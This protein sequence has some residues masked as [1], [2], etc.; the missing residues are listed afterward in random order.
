MLPRLLASRAAAAFKISLI[1]SSLGLFCAFTVYA[2]GSVSTCTEEALRTALAGGGTVT[3]S[4]NCSITLT[5]PL[6]I[7]LATTIDA[8]NHDVTISGGNAVSLFNVTANLNL[9]GLT[10]SNG[11][12][13]NGTGGCMHIHSGATVR[14]SDCSFVANSVQGLNGFAGSNGSTNSNGAGG[15]GGNG[16]AGLSGLGGAIYNLGNLTLVGCNFMTN[17]ATGGNGGKGGNGGAGGGTLSQGGDGGDGGAGAAGFGG[18]IYNLNNTTLISCTFSNNAAF[19]GNGGVGGT[20]GAGI[21]PSLQG[22][23]GP[24]EAGSGGSIYNARNLTVRS[25]TFAKN[26]AESGISA[27]GGNQTSGVGST[28]AA[29]PDSLGGALCNLWWGV[30]TN[31]TFFGNAAFGGI[32]GNGGNGSGSLP[33]GGNGGN[34]GN[35]AGG[36]LY[37]SG[38]FTLVNCT[39]SDNGAVGGTNGVAGSGNFASS[40]GQMGQSLGGNIAAAGGSLNVMN[41]ILNASSSGANAF[42]AFTDGGYN[43]SSDTVDSFDSSTLQNTDPKLGP[44]ANNGGPTFTM[45]LLK[46]SPAVDVIP[47]NRAPQS[48]QRGISRPQGDASDIG[49]YEFTGSSLPLIL[50]QPSDLVVTQN[51]TA[52]FTV[53]AGGMTPLSYQWSFNGTNITSATSPSYTIPVVD[54]T[55]AGGYSVIISNSLGSTNSRTATLTVLLPVSGVVTQGTNGLSGVT[56]SILGADNTTTI[57]TDTNGAYTVAL[58]PGTYTVAPALTNY[59][60]QPPSLSLTIPPSTNGVNFAASPL[61]TISR[62]TNGLV[63]L[64]SFGSTGMTF[65][66]Q[67]STNLVNW[68][69]LSTNLAP[70]QF[71]DGISNGSA[72]FYRLKLQ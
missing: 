33:Q 34:G 39:F 11:R 59:A 52:V 6:S 24:G 44:L 9:A 40:N 4:T 49:A 36:G 60:F 1:A 37:N 45:A 69:D 65:Q 8:S 32:G 50:Q 29:G 31:C 68:Q 22:K 55:N 38:T 54:G 18:A 42:G 20:N 12:S 28:G 70:L 27:P 66:I 71:T 16:T 7:T 67:I 53:V 5:R 64:T 57:V 10:L 17:T 62:L 23:G 63:Q 48:D 3:F 58:P 30:A 61:F 43:L 15:N 46:R 51:S 2:G 56:I 21:F 13:T 41:S 25:C 47:P 26:I 35:G 14:A 72:R 19:G